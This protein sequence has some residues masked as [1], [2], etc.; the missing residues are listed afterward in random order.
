MAGLQVRAGQSGVRA[1]WGAI[2][3]A[4]PLSLRHPNSTCDEGIN[5]RHSSSTSSL[6]YVRIITAVHSI[7]T[8]F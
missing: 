1:P 4:V 7:Y 2:T 3:V 5:N 8:C 6:L